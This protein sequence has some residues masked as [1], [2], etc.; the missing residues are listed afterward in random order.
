MPTT[1]KR[2]RK[3]LPWKKFLTAE[4]MVMIGTLSDT[5]SNAKKRL[6]TASQERALIQN[7][8]TVRARRAM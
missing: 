6:R 1:N 5:I 4:E 3:P 7:R 2:K 8:A